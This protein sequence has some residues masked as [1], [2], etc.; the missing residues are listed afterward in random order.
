M[1]NDYSKWYGL[2]YAIC[3][4]YN[5]FGPREKGDGKY[6]SL[7]ARFQKLYTEGRPLT[8][9][10]PGTQKRNFTY[11][12]D[13]AKG[14]LLVAKKGKGDSYALNN[15]KSYSVKEIA[16]A[17]GGDIVYRENYSGR[18]D[19]GKTPDRA[20]AELDWSTEIDVID[21]INEFKS[22]LKRS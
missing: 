18:K 9:D 19:S 10:L 15:P 6:A 11:V 7:I 14:M 13:L 2:N 5:A 8:V 22:K 21:Y 16:E 17:F 20:Y 4:F 3:Y 12:K 1:V